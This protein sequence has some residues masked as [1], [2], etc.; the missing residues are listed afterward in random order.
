MRHGWRRGW[1]LALFSAI[2]ALGAGAAS[3]D[4]SS[5]PSPGEVATY[6]PFNDTAVIFNTVAKAD[7][8]ATADLGDVNKI[9]GDEGYQ[10]RRYGPG[11]G[12]PDTVANFLA[13]AKLPS[14]IIVI[15]SA[16]RLSP[17]YALAVEIDRTDKVAERTYA[18]LVRKPGGSSWFVRDGSLIA[19]TQKGLK[20]YF[21]NNKHNHDLVV[22]LACNSARTASVFST[23]AFV[24]FRQAGSGCSVSGV[25]HAAHVAD[26]VFER[27][28]GHSGV[29]YRSVLAAW[30]LGGVSGGKPSGIL[31]LQKVGGA[32]YAPVLSPAVTSAS[33]EGEDSGLTAGGDY[34][35]SVSFDALM[36]SSKPNSVMQ[37]SGCG[38]SIT[39]AK[40][41]DA[42]TTL[43]FT[44]HLPDGQSG[45]EMKFT[46]GHT[47]AEAHGGL[48]NDELSGNQ[49]P[50]PASGEA[51]NRTDYSWQVS[52]DPDVIPI[53]I[54]M[55]GTFTD[56]DHDPS[57]QNPGLGASDVN[58]SYTWTVT[59]FATV[60]L[61]GSA[62][63]ITEG[64]GSQT[65]TGSETQTY[66]G[67]STSCTY[68][69]ASATPNAGVTSA[70]LSVQGTQ[71]T[72]KISVYADLPMAAVGPG[73]C[74]VEPVS[75]LHPAEGID[76][77]TDGP[78]TLQAADSGQTTVDLAQL[79][80]GPMTVTY[81]VNYTDSARTEP[82]ASIT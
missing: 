43:D 46:V 38:A 36:D 71:Q 18:G 70:A 41:T 3:V 67:G 33:V 68:T 72:W 22:D 27:M 60:A 52:C 62:G 63:D 35:G 56:S 58:G 81:P 5:L 73:D 10:V 55:N 34:T 21:A 50:S 25:N 9:L 49:P 57:D 80:K 8:A 11:G 29:Q 13:L 32:D 79:E 76:S 30:D 6:A 44:V 53:K 69:P 82:A 74:A 48:P 20:H 28:A 24:G 31:K 7:A 15:S 78:A 40:W 23:V 12:A 1:V 4:A 47:A 77:P 65:L 61:R 17:S 37:V 2:V 59:Q 45:G 66:P 14:A 51:P 64:T 42:E 39:Q 54:Q 16:D 26:A 19:I 75:F